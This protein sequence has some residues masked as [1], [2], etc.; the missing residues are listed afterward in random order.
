M[1]FELLR[2]NLTNEDR[3]WE[4]DKDGCLPYGFH[5]ATYSTCYSRRHFALQPHG[6]NFSQLRAR[7]PAHCSIP[8]GLDP[9]DATMLV[10]LVT[11]PQAVR[12]GKLG[13][14]EAAMELF[15][16]VPKGL[17]MPERT[18]HLNP[19]RTSIFQAR[20]LILN[21][22]EAPW[23]EHLLGTNND[24]MLVLSFYQNRANSQ[25]HYGDP[26]GT[27]CHQWEMAL[28]LQ[29]LGMSDVTAFA[30][31]RAHPKL[32]YPIGDSNLGFENISKFIDGLQSSNA[33]AIKDAWGQ[34]GPAW[35]AEYTDE[36]K[37]S[38][39]TQKI[40]LDFD[41]SGGTRQSIFTRCYRTYSIQFW[42]LA[43]F[44]ESKLKARFYFQRFKA[45]TSKIAK[46]EAVPC[47]YTDVLVLIFV[48]LRN[49]ITGYQETIDAI[50]FASA[51]D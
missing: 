2:M 12:N 30:M 51:S 8:E 17:P 29:T 33:G 15:L 41:Q 44:Q 47:E 19:R 36:Y 13:L 45:I 24:L 7:L 16:P 26:Y 49:N 14:V 37:L 22:P 23:Y 3:K 34:I 4:L 35:S 48:W 38:H 20:R 46:V 10:D 42:P 25:L 11:S 43:K 21:L 28:H 6:F 40:G 31:I 5:M 27:F 18:T 39:V 32:R 50:K 1:P 9:K